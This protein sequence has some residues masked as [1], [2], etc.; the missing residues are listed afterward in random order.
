MPFRAD[1]LTIRVIL[2]NAQYHTL[3]IIL[4]IAQRRRLANV[5]E[6][7]AG[8]REAT[9]HVNKKITSKFLCL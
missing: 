1:D 6:V 2:Y 5:S 3:A 8:E 4:Q 7:T 9:L